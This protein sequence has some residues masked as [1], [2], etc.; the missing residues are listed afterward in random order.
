MEAKTMTKS[1]NIITKRH[2]FVDI[3]WIAYGVYLFVYNDW[4]NKK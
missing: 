2:N 4:E 1:L 3:G